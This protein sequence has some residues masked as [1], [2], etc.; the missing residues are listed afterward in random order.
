MDA[1][2]LKK[3][4][5]R[6]VVKGRPDRAEV[7]YRQVVSLVPRDAPS[8]LRHAETLCKLGRTADAVWS[9][10]QA[11]TLLLTLGHQTRAIAAL[12][13]ALEL[14]PDD[15]DLVSDIIR[16]EMQRTRPPAMFPPRAPQPV[17]PLERLEEPQL[18]L[19]MHTDDAITE[20]GM[21]SGEF[22]IEVDLGERNFD[23]EPTELDLDPPV[24]AADPEPR[25]VAPM[26]Q[27]TWPQVRRL[28]DREVAVKAGPDAQWLVV[29]SAAPLDVKFHS[30]LAV[31]SET[32]WVG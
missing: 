30:S 23:E 1:R 32:N 17:V 11:A 22:V 8:W 26:V 20:P 19:P 7:L 12:K 21:R 2:D 13:L 14:V 28:N 31:D 16:L 29:T 18:A 15:V 25:P 10:R 6:Q 24:A 27:P 4:A 9:Y 3:Q 5:Q